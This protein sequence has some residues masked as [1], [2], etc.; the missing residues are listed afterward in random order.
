VTG[1]GPE[2]DVAEDGGEPVV[3]AAHPV[4]NENGA[5]RQ[6]PTPLLLLT[7]VLHLDVDEERG[8]G[9]VFFSLGITTVEDSRQRA[10]C[11]DLLYI[12][13]RVRQAID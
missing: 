8:V 11:E 2:P 3:E 10:P 7:A 5:H 12:Y 4:K 9:C 13:T 6:S 1:G